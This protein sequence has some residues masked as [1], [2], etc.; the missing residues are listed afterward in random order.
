MV[1]RSAVE[2]SPHRTEID[3]RLLRGESPRQV[4]KWLKNLKKDPEKI[5]HTAINKYRKKHLN[6]QKEVVEKYQDRQTK[7][8]K[9]VAVKK[10]VCELEALD[11]IIESGTNLKIALDQITPDKSTTPLDIE[12][13]KLQAKR[14]VIQAT[15]AKHEIT[16]DN[17]EPI[18]NV[19]VDLYGVPT[20]P[21]IRARARDL[22]QQIRSSE[23]EPSNPGHG[24]Q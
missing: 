19:K 22:I 2:Q 6:V 17:P 20:D 11:E 12:K 10:G 8:R 16:K 18:V 21:A 5:S 7:R 3:K 15:T 1:L 13:V 24:G 14:L 4:S 23:M 9:D